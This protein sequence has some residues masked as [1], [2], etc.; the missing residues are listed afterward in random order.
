V[1]WIVLEEVDE[2]AARLIALRPATGERRLLYRSE[3]PFP[4]RPSLHPEGTRIALDAISRNVLRGEYRA[5]VGIVN[6]E[7]GGVGWL[8]QSLDPKWRVGGAV[9]DP[10]GRLL[11]IEGA[12]DGAP[13][14]ELY[15][16][17]VSFTGNSAN[18]VIVAGAGNRQRL[19]TA[20]PTF[21]PSGRQ[22]VYLHNDR[23]DGAWEVHLLDL[24]QSG[25]SAFSMEG[26]APSVLSLPLTEGALAQ[27]DAGLVFSPERGRVFFV[28][29][30][31]SRT[32]Q[33][34][35]WTPV[36]G[37]GIVDLGREHLRIEEVVVAPGTD[38]VAY[39]ADGNIYLA[40]AESCEV[41]LLMRG[42][43]T[44][45]HRGLIFDGEAGGLWFTTTDSDGAALRMVDLDTREVRDVVSLGP[46][47]AV[48]HA[49]ALPDTPRT[50]SLVR[51]LPEAA[52]NLGEATIDQ[53][54][55][56]HA[57]DGD[58]DRPTTVTRVTPNL[59]TDTVPNYDVRGLATAQNRVGDGPA[60]MPGD[61]PD[62]P[63]EPPKL[64]RDQTQVTPMPVQRPAALLPPAPVSTPAPRLVTAPVLE[65]RG[66]PAPTPFPIADSSAEPASSIPDRAGT[67]VEVSDSML[68][69]PPEPQV[70]ATAPS[71]ASEDTAPSIPQAPPA[72]P[73]EDFV[74]WMKSLPGH[75][76]PGDQL[77]R[78]AAPDTVG[79]PRLRDAARMYLGLQARKA[80]TGGETL[81]ELVNAIGAAGHLRLHEGEATLRQLCEA[82]RKRLRADA[83]LPEVEEHYALAA[84]R[85]IRLGQ[86]FDFDEVFEEYESMLAQSAAVLESGGEAAAIRVIGTFG[87]MYL[88][89]IT[90]ALDPA[91]KPQAS[92]IESSRARDGMTRNPSAVKR[93]GTLPGLSVPRFADVPADVPAEV[94]AASE[95][96]A[97]EDTSAAGAPAR[98]PLPSSP[99]EGIAAVATPARVAP[100]A[101][102]T[103]SSPQPTAVSHSRPDEA[104]DE[105]E[106]A[107]LRARA[108]FDA[109]AD[110]A[111]ATG[112]DRSPIPV[113][114]DVDE[115]EWRH[116]R[117]RAEAASRP[118]L[119][120]QRTPSRPDFDPFG[121][122]GA[123]PIP[124]PV[125]PIASRSSSGNSGRRWPGLESLDSE[126]FAPIMTG[127][128]SLTMPPP[129]WYAQVV[130]GAA[131]IGGLVECLLGFQL[132]LVLLLLG[133]AT[134]VA[135][136]GVLGDRRWGYLAAGP[137]FAVNAAYL[138]SYASSAP[139][140][141]VPP[142]ALL[143]GAA[144]A[145]MAFF[146]MLAPDI[147]ARYTTRRG[148]I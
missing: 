137:V 40:D 118:V 135:G 12:F 108:R 65:Q 139:P 22:L 36:D 70:P 91:A 98:T 34:V 26:R 90:E 6:L 59:Q 79:E 107:R 11:A 30:T 61:V 50:R 80:G 85:A 87:Q 147:R 23:P 103:E 38:F 58:D 71:P 3:H 144:A 75:A 37:G 117:A 123:T 54:P 124:A 131:G 111:A 20:A 115:A 17:K 45:S 121:P 88:D 113:T 51:T 146:V 64:S 120:A 9:F 93:S 126:G 43:P 119:A 95:G 4:L 15:I 102:A 47:V 96:S 49:L 72:D 78:L 35:H 67:S 112:A 19:G 92:A 68:E 27:V 7:N 2:G 16:L 62:T 57:D 97:S 33:R 130:G 129:P 81:N 106:W 69:E 132:G 21:L 18:E 100:V 31:R 110:V 74:G 116:A 10:T 143:I 145:T 25:D 48:V 63:E 52:T 114:D 42:E 133:V 148:R 13:L 105:A 125:A 41:H 56:G 46:G 66:T 122:G 99:N 94:P 86:R 82:C 5:R 101:A 76:A 14:T 77:R 55:G 142:M 136:F 1:E 104:D 141:W 140:A 84:L 134:L 24:D 8:K 60:V 44:S 83:S 39:A 32:R 138:A 73:R 28:G 89:L 29:Q 128:I 127:E 109:P 53:G